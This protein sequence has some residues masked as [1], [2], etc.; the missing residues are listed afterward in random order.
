MAFKNIIIISDNFQ[1][2]ETF[3]EVV[4][5][6]NL[7][8]S[9]FTFAYSYNN[10]KISDDFI[11]GNIKAFPI[12][13]KQDYP[14]IIKKYDLV[15]S[16]HC[17]QLFPAELV[18]AVKC[19]N[20][21]PGLNPYNRGW[22][23]QVFSI[24]NKLPLGATI[25]EIDEDLDHGSIIAQKEVPVYS[26]DTSLSAYNRVQAAEIA[27]LNTHIESILSGQ[28]STIQ[29]NSEGN[30]NLMKDF[31]ALCKLEIEKQQTIG[32]TID[33]LRALTHGE[34]KNAYFF[35]PNSGKRIF[36]SISLET[37]EQN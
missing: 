20:I 5:S 35:D 10:L 3:I 12:N 1:L 31:N 16:V 19:I 26:F 37:D 33:L 15:I 23:P 14:S 11:K 36:V 24:V 7:S 22:F 4:L 32:E 29:A 6:K 28:Y 21:H 18:K 13:V 25:H 2:C 34:Y 27:L 30:L 17:K 9:N 8:L